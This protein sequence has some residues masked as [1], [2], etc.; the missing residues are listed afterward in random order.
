MTLQIRRFAVADTDAVTGLWAEAFPHDPP[1]N[2]PKQVIARKIARD[3]ELFWVAVDASA[4]GEPVG[5][6]MAGYDGVRGWLYHLAVTPPRRGEGI[7]KAL[8]LHA[9]GE[10][11]ALGCPK[12][13]LQVRGSNTGVIAFYEAL[14]WQEDDT[15]ALGLLF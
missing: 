5:V 10:L 11:R 4:M 2:D 14:G 1:R 6:V 12:V 3:P 9:V 13:N 8:T 15:T 7:A